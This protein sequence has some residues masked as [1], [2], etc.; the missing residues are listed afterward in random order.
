MPVSAPAVADG[1][2]S[3]GERFE[4]PKAPASGWPVGE[5]VLSE[6]D[7]DRVD[8]LRATYLSGLPCLN[9]RATSAPIPATKPSTSLNHR[10]STQP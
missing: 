10:E 8:G 6:I 1:E 4:S 3:G 9:A 2:F 5:E 7:S